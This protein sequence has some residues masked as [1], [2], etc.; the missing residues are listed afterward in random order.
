[1][2]QSE[3]AV[4]NTMAIE[5]YVNRPRVVVSM[6]KTLPKIS[7]KNST[8]RPLVTKESVLYSP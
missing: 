6:P 5:A 4:S 3:L 2:I 8:P 1:M 7:A